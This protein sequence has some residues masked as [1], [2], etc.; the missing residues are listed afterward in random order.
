[1]NIEKLWRLRRGKIVKFGNSPILPDWSRND[2]QKQEKA[3]KWEQVGERW[4]WKWGF[5]RPCGARNRLRITIIGFHNTNWAGFCKRLQNST[6]SVD[7]YDKN[8]ITAP[9]FCR[10]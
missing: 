8:H 6:I 1:M 3:P 9:G 7:R 2:T 10:K 4:G 5:G